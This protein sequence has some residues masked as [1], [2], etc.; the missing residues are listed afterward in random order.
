M[1]DGL[2]LTVS[3]AETGAGQTEKGEAKKMDVTGKDGKVSV[4]TPALENEG[5]WQL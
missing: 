4:R 3:V 1:K 2:L 5:S